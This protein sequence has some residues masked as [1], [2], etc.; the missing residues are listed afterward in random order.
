MLSLIVLLL[1]ATMM[2]AFTKPSLPISSL[3]PIKKTLAREYASFFNPLERSIYSPT[4]D[5]T[6]PLASLNS[7]TDYEKNIQM[8]NGRG[9]L[10]GILFDSAG[11]RGNRRD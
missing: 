11:F 2:Q 7:I 5:F 9:L 8:L 4:L 6:D 10:G 3:D 1:V